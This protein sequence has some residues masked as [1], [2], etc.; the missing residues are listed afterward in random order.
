V[1]TT[2]I[3]PTYNERENIEPLARQLFALKRDIC[4]IVVDDNSP[5]GTGE[6]ADVLAR[7]EPRL[8]VL[9]RPSKLGLGTAHIAGF[10][11]ALADGADFIV[12]MDADFSH[13]PRYIS[14]LLDQAR[15]FDL[16]IGSRYVNGGGMLGCTF[17]RKLLSWGANVFTRIMLG[18]SAHD[19]T[20]GFRC[21]RRHVLGTIDLDHIFSDGYSFLIEMLDKCQQAG[22][23]V[24]EV[25]I[26][27]ENR[28]RGRSKISQTEVLKALYTV[29]RLRWERIL[30]HT[31][32]QQTGLRSSIVEEER[33]CQRSEH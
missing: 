11:Q 3:V 20:A 7:S 29:F 28:Q 14:Q 10:C 1:K 24:G 31:C 33:R 12:T 25:P 32:P 8:K 21:Y 4:L 16:V 18:L 9:H 5:D 23:R 13:N 22:Y 17:D 27:F 15:T 26:I 6:L 2:V 19:C 30:R